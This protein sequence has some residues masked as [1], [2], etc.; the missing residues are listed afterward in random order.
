MIFDKLPD[1][2]VDASLV[3]SPSGRQQIRDACLEELREIE[4]HL[5]VKTFA[6]D[7]ENDILLLAAALNE[8]DRLTRLIADAEHWLSL[9][10]T[11][12]SDRELVAGLIL[13]LR[14][15][16]NPRLGE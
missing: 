6:C 10:A 4:E 12:N 5:V 16:N 1:Y 8:I 13:R 3:E 11:S 14:K 2:V 15:V 9:P 7:V